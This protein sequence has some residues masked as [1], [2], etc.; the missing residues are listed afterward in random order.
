MVRTKSSPVKFWNKTLYLNVK[1]NLIA[2][3]HL[4]C[5]SS[6]KQER[7]R[8]FSVLCTCLEQDTRNYLSKDCKTGRIICFGEKRVVAVSW[9]KL[10]STSKNIYGIFELVTLT[11]LYNCQMRH[12]NMGFCLEAQ[13][14]F[15]MLTM[16]TANNKL[17]WERAHYFVSKEI[18][19]YGF[20]FV[21]IYFC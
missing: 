9:H 11:H 13:N 10:D 17:V 12:L 8:V 15:I 14:K 21:F 16:Y 4:Y 3:W 20:V 6:E 2:C 7:R 18:W 5:S 19:I 1:L